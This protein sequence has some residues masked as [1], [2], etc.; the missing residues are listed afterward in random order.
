MTPDQKPHRWRGGRR[1]A[2]LSALLFA[3]AG[4]G[5]GVPE[6]RLNIDTLPA[7][8]VELAIIAYVYPEQGPAVSVALNPIGLKDE[9]QDVSFGLDLQGKVSDQPAEFS[10]AAK[11]ASG[12]IVATGATERVQR[13]TG[14]V[15]RDVPLHMQPT[16]GL[17]A[18]GACKTT[19][20]VI[21]SAERVQRG[22][23]HA[24]D[25][26]LILHGWNWSKQYWPQ[27]RSTGAIFCDPQPMP[28][29]PPGQPTYPLCDTLTCSPVEC[30]RESLTDRP[31]K[32][33]CLM[34]TSSVQRGGSRID[35]SVSAPDGLSKDAANSVLS[36]PLVIRLEP[37]ADAFGTYDERPPMPPK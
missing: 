33:D 18:A 13:R 24:Q 32:K 30:A 27:V 15:V 23:W 9:R 21:L 26:Q 37:G 8:A 25:F 10:V 35:V 2:G 3:S 11:D 31:C 22:L 5:C 1:L 6:Y 12:C 16:S 36:Q 29:P 28:P 14:D 17:A 20:P 34:T 7:E 19:Q 4:V